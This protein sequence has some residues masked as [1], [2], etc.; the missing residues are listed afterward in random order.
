MSGEE[1]E[2]KYEEIAKIVDQF[3]DVKFDKN[4]HKRFLQE[5]DEYFRKHHL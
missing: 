4:D 5:I 1:R 2:K 3:K